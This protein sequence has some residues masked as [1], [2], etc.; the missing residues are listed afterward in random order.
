MKEC[1]PSAGCLNTSNGRSECLKERL[2]KCRRTLQSFHG[3]AAGKIS[4]QNKEHKTQMYDQ[5]YFL[6]YG[7][8]PPGVTS[9]PRLIWHKF[10][11]INLDFGI[12]LL[13]IHAGATKSSRGWRYKAA[14]LTVSV[15]RCGSANLQFQLCDG[16]LM[17]HTLKTTN[18]KE[19]NVLRTDFSNKMLLNNLIKSV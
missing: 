14:G 19:D 17:S 9:D 15:L 12:S 13:K 10:Y 1:V 4:S 18:L 5:S 16:R 11:T 6:T 7:C 8:F 2:S 3:V